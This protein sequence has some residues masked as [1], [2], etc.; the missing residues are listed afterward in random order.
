MRARATFYDILINELRLRS[1]VLARL[2]VILDIK[3]RDTRE[4]IPFKSVVRFRSGKYR[5]RNFYAFFRSRE[6]RV[7]GLIGRHLSK[8]KHRAIKRCRNRTSSDLATLLGEKTRENERKRENIA[9]LKVH[10][11]PRDTVELSSKLM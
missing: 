8:I 7:V 10:L 1:T 2:F 6:Q 11:L 3:K 5:E 9:R 4:R